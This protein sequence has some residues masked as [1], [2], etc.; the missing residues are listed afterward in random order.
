MFGS[1]CTNKVIVASKDRI[2]K[3]SILRKGN[4]DFCVPDYPRVGLY[5]LPW[6]NQEKKHTS[7]LTKRFRQKL[8][9]VEGMTLTLSSAVPP[10]LRK[11][12]QF[13]KRFGQKL[14]DVEGMTLTLSS[15]VPPHLRKIRENCQFTERFWS[16]L[17]HVEGMT[18]TLPYNT[19]DT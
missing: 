17:G 16:E 3:L 15:A 1:Y 14:G 18:L 4:L 5:P 6:D 9:H 11:I 7:Q 12:C 8:E 10:H 19:L 2:F 13:T